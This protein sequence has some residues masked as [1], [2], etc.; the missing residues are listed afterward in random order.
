M[1]FKIIENILDPQDANYITNIILSTDFP[2]YFNKNSANEN[3]PEN[4]TYSFS[5]MLYTDEGGR[6]IFFDKFENIL[7]KLLQK[8][9]IKGKLLRARFG[10][11]TSNKIKKIDDKHIDSLSEHD[12]ILYYLNDSDGDTYFY[13]KKKIIKQITPQF[14]KAIFFNGNIYHSSSKP[15]KSNRRVVLN[16]NVTKQ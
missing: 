11:H 13:N 4:G 15:V 8:F 6:T 2:W 3:N 14:N 5:H 16:L 9:N 12:V 10:L 1:N 7:I